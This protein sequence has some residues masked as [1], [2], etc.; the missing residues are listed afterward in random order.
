MGE[1]ISGISVLLG[2]A[3]VSTIIT[4]IFNQYNNRKSNALKYI[5][6]E[7]KAWRE[8]IRLIGEKIQECE[9]EGKGEK[10]I[11]KYL[12]ELE[13]NINSYGRGSTR[14]VKDDAYIW[15][16][17]DEIRE[18]DS[19]DCFIRHKELLIYYISLMI[20]ED[21]DR[22]KN[23]VVGL[24][25]MFVEVLTIMFINLGLTCFY[26]FIG[27]ST[28]DIWVA[29]S[30]RVIIYTAAIY[31]IF[32][33]M[34]AFAYMNII[35]IN[36]KTYLVF[37]GK[38]IAVLLFVVCFICPI[39]FYLF[40]FLMQKFPNEY[41]INGITGIICY[42]ESVKIFWNWFDNNLKKL[43]LSLQVIYSREKI[44]KESDIKIKTYRKNTEE[45]YQ[46]IRDNQNDVNKVKRSVVNV[47]LN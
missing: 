19:E 39:I 47:G 31:I 15:N 26:L 45:I 7:R 44:L 33:G 18:V 21:W 9:F 27:K 34:Q 1:V 12:V 8:S 4:T 46:Y 22:S 42:V 24:S 40:R 41:L 2:S 16:E 6:E 25:Q 38:I 28:L 11:E 43:R 29:V 3:V 23:E 35:T 14:S 17:I 32:K 20:K 13:L 30:A 5:T 36:R 37:L 10:D